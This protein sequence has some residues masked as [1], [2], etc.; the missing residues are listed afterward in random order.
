MRDDALKRHHLRDLLAQVLV[1]LAGAVLQ[2]DLAA[3]GDDTPHHLADVAEWKAADVWHAASER[4]HLGAA[5]HGEESSNLGRA[6][7]MGAGGV[8]IQPGVEA[9]A[10]GHRGHVWRALIHADSVSCPTLATARATG[11]LRW[12][13][14]TAD[15][16]AVLWSRAP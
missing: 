15:S 5:R 2:G 9:S 8:G 6:H 7:A 11:T 1:A 4:H 12:G 10:L 13:P 16:L 14:V 3:L